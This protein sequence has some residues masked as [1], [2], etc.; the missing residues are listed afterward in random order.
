MGLTDFLLDFASEYVE[1]RGAENAVR[2]VVGF[3]DWLTDDDTSS[4]QNVQSNN[5]SNA[6]DDD[7]DYEDELT[8]E[9]RYMT[10]SNIEENHYQFAMSDLDRMYKYHEY[11]KDLRYYVFAIDICSQI[12]RNLSGVWAYDENSRVCLKEFFVYLNKII[13]LAKAQNMTLD[14][15][16]WDE[17]GELCEEVM[18]DEYV[19][20]Y[21][22][23]KQ[24]TRELFDN[25]EFEKSL[26]LL[27]KFIK[28]EDCDSCDIWSWIDKCSIYS[29]WYKSLPAH[30]EKLEELKEEAIHSLNMAQVLASAYK[31]CE[32]ELEELTSRVNEALASHDNDDEQQ[33]L[34][35]ATPAIP[36]TPSTPSLDENAEQEYL[37][38]VR[39][40]LEDDG[41]I[42][43]RERRLLNKLAQSLGI[44]EERAAQLEAQAQMPIT[45]LIPPE[46][47]YADEIRACLADDGEITER[48]RRLLNKIRTSLGITE[49]RAAEIEKYIH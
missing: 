38:E 42:S 13:Q 48:E 37:D 30:H 20:K 29:M 22:N 3:M 31:Y 14:G 7:D 17:I 10:K 5:Y 8:A 49:E 45:P 41:E 6:Y 35:P 25:G 23:V 11:V 12:L 9:Y 21:L 40:C 36:S 19:K 34:P 43:D 4:Q 24:K 46:Q 27:E 26:S 1:E 39:A 47:E 28:E 33:L 16:Y 15:E 18:A 2:D 32:E 44:S